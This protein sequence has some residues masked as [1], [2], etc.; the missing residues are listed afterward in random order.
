MGCSPTA[1]PTAAWATSP[2]STT[3]PPPSARTTSLPSTTPTPTPNSR[4]NRGDPPLLD[5]IHR[6]PS[7][8]YNP[9]NRSYN[10]LWPPRIAL[11]HEGSN[12]EHCDEFLF[13]IHWRHV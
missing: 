7:T 1:P 2:R 11:A 5:G 10:R 3:F 12:Q 8:Q 9:E 6:W 13:Y 4:A